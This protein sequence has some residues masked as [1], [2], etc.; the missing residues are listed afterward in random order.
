MN[1][2]AASWILHPVVHHQNQRLARSCAD[3]LLNFGCLAEQALPNQ[4]LFS[5]TEVQTA[6]LCEASESSFQNLVLR[7][8]LPQS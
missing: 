3:E 2:M 7:P 4:S 5:L 8:S 1:T 6:F